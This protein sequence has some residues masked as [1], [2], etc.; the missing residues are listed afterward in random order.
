MRPRSIRQLLQDIQ[1][2]VRDIEDLT[3]GFTF[4]QYVSTKAVRLAVERQFISIG[5]A[6]SRL[7]RVSGESRSRIDEA[8][9]ITRFRNFLVHEYEAVDDEQ[10]WNVVQHSLPLLKQQINM[11][12]AELGME[13]PPEG[14]I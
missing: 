14:T 9:S 7:K 8:I 5:E 6:I 3:N 1:L 2:C 10:V 11:W 12:A 13:A 4:Q